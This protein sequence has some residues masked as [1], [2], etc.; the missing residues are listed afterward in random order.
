MGLALDDNHDERTEHTC[1]VLPRVCTA[2]ALGLPGEVY[3]VTVIVREVEKSSRMTCV[4]QRLGGW[5]ANS[6][7]VGERTHKE[8]T[9]RR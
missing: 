6:R 9:A 7:Q 2:P 5:S 3:R 8:R 4:Q 1:H